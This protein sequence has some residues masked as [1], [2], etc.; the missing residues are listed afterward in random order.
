MQGVRISTATAFVVFVILC[1]LFLWV[2]RYEVVP[3]ATEKHA[4][5]YRLN[6]WTGS[7]D[8][9]YRTEIHAMKVYRPQKPQPDKSLRALQALEEA[10]RSGKYED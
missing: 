2:F 8:L 7:V 10:A 1:L 5:A 3:I 9:L 6:R 4:A